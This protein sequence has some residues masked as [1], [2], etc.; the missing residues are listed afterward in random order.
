M[1]V[2]KIFSFPIMFSRSRSTPLRTFSHFL[3]VWGLTPYQQYFSYLTHSHTMTPF[4]TLGNKPF[5]NTVGKGETARYEQFLLFP[6]CFL[7]VLIAFFHCHIIWNCHLQTLS[8]WRSLK[9]VVWQWVNNGT[10]Q[11]HVS[12][13]IFNQYLTS[14]LS[15]HWHDSHSAIPTILSAKGQS[16][17]YQ[18]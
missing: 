5:E 18:F 15:W 17:Y 7:P 2:T 6:Q 8:V 12:K 1:L 14:Q 16:H 3:F 13:T 11:I 9:F 4:D 10:P